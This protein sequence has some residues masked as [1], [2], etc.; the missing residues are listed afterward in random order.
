M[1]DFEFLKD[2]N[3]IKD[4]GA[5][6]EFEKLLYKS[7]SENSPNGWLIKNY[8]TIDNSRL[9]PTVPYEDVFIFVAKKDGQI[10]A[11]ISGTLNMNN[12]LQLEKMGFDVDKHTNP[13]CEGLNFYISDDLGEGFLK[14]LG[15]FLDRIVTELKLRNIDCIYSTCSK[16][17]RNMYMMFDF[18]ILDSRDLD[19][20]EEFLIRYRF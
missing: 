17:L 12:E 13:F 16:K 6:T 7:F 3:S 14:V 10:V 5:L 19:G 15:G 20:D 4:E 8:K 9:L 18:E 1:I 2:E 11:G